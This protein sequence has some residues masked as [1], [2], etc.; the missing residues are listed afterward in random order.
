MDHRPAKRRRVAEPQHAV[1][2]AN[3]RKRQYDNMHRRDGAAKERRAVIS[4]VEN[5]DD[6]ITV[7]VA[8]NDD[9]VATGTSTVT[10]D[11]GA[12]V[13]IVI[14]GDATTTASVTSTLIST[15]TS[16]PKTSQTSSRVSTPSTSA[17]PARSTTQAPVT[18][19]TSPTTT[20]P[21]IT[22]IPSEASLLMTIDAAPTNTSSTSLEPSTTTFSTLTPFFNATV[23]SNSTLYQQYNFKNTTTSVDEYITSTTTVDPSTSVVATSDSQPTMITYTSTVMGAPV[24]AAVPTSGT[25]GTAS[26]NND[27]SDNNNQA[28]PVAPPPVI[29]GAVTGSV[30]AAAIIAV[31]LLLL[32][33]W[34]RKRLDKQSVTLTGGERFLKARPGSSND[35]EPAM[36]HNRSSFLPAAAAAFISRHRHQIKSAQPTLPNVEPSFQKVQGRKIPSQFGHDAVEAPMFRDFEIAPAAGSSPSTLQ[37]GRTPL[38]R[39]MFSDQ[40]AYKES[41]QSRGISLD[42]ASLMN[43]FGDD[44]QEYTRPERETVMPSPARTPVIQQGTPVL[45]QGLYFLPP[46]GTFRDTYDGRNLVTPSPPGTPQ[47]MGY[48]PEDGSYS[49]SAY[50]DPARRASRFAEVGYHRTP[51]NTCSELDDIMMQNNL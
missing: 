12:V 21:L 2:H 49:G 33:R 43:P 44:A 48:S 34:Y 51:S 7:V 23:F 22:T 30:G 20:T 31:I 10:A 36:I 5:I 19:T 3:Y 29:A 45:E 18:S 32:L 37:N 41:R 16:K 38:H 8:A 25:T 28:A 26:R 6:A 4:I 9:G 35:S 47:M 40:S 14:G 24:V 39:S 46:P 42:A 17:S 15:S 50:I 1:Y 11:P 13:S 27:N